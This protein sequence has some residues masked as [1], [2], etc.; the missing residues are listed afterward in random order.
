MKTH[1][2]QVAEGLGALHAI[3]LEFQHTTISRGKLYFAALS[4]RF[5]ELFAQ[6]GPAAHIAQIACGHQGHEHQGAAAN[7]RPHPTGEQD[8]DARQAQQCAHSIHH[9][10]GLAL[11]VPQ[12]NQPVVD[13]LCIRAEQGHPAH[14]PA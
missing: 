1:R 5:V 11:A 8:A 13:V 3:S 2:E 10:Q 14:G 7:H 4:Q 12:Q 6:G 9:G